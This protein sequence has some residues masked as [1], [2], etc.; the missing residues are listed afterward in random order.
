[1]QQLFSFINSYW[2]LGSSIIRFAFYK[3]R[4]VFGVTHC[5]GTE[6]I[7]SYT[8][9]IIIIYKNTMN[10]FCVDFFLIFFQTVCN[11]EKQSMIK[12]ELYYNTTSNLG[13]SN[14]GNVELEIY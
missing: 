10:H 11:D 14:L 7:K 12:S 2:W 8:Y 4:K 1:M 13:N 3:Q 6:I 5:T 9:I